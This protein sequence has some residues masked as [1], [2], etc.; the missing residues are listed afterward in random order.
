MSVDEIT[1]AYLT[2]SATRGLGP[3]KIRLLVEALGSARTVLEASAAELLEVESIGPSMVAALEQ[4]K[5]SDWPTKE[6][7]RAR[8]LGTE[9]LHLEHPDYPS[10]LLSIYDPPAVL[11]CRGALPKLEAGRPRSIGIVGT[12]D[13]SDYALSFA[14]KLAT[15]LAE[16]N[17][18]V[19]SGLALGIDTIAHEGSLAARGQTLAVLGSGVDVI[20]PGK[21]QALAHKIIQGHGAVLSEYPIGSRPIATNFPARNRIINGLSSGIVVVEAGQKSGALITADYAL[22]E[23]HSVFAVPGRVGDPRSSGTLALL[24][25]GAQLVESAED[26]LSSF[27]W[28]KGSGQNQ[29]TVIQLTPSEEQVVK[30]IATLQHPALDDLSLHL[31]QPAPQLL[32]TLTMLELRGVVKQLPGGRY[33]VIRF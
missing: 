7:E 18:C 15:D 25:Q 13:A 14:R 5:T 26:I 27:D 22:E 21:N 11:Y 31:Q 9:I 12:R 30:V 29:P 16:A 8:K 6:I 4:A 3:R 24:K 19:V 23:G 28:L 20:Y 33:G 32:A 2:L 10:C 17:V 1:Q